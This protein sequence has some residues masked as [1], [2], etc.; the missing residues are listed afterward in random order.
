MKDFVLSIVFFFIK[1]ILF[2]MGFFSSFVFLA[3]L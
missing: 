1:K 2:T 3:A